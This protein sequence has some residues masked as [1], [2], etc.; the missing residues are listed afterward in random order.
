MSIKELYE[1]YKIL[2]LSRIIKLLPFPPTFPQKSACLQCRRCHC[3]SAYTKN[4]KRT[5]FHIKQSIEAHTRPA[6]KTPPPPLILS[7][8]ATQLPR[9]IISAQHLKER[10]VA[11]VHA[12]STRTKDGHPAILPIPTTAVTNPVANV[13]LW[14]RRQL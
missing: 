9:G 12:T 4:S 6:S 2:M 7:P 14:W 13:G 1:L 5:I 10:V 8:P 3:Y 11:P